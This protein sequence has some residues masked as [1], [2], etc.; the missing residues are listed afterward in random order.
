MR[1]AYSTPMA[2]TGLV[3]LGLAFFGRPDVY[4]R[5][6]RAQWEQFLDGTSPDRESASRNV[7]AT[8]TPN[9]V[10]AEISRLQEQVKHL[11]ADLQANQPKQDTSPARTVTPPPPAAVAVPDHHDVFIPPPVPSAAPPAPPPTVTIQTA[12]PRRAAPLP[13]ASSPIEN[14]DTL[15]SVMARLRQQPLDRPPPAIPQQPAAIPPLQPPQLPSRSHERLLQARA[16]LQAGH[17]QDAM[18][19]LQEAQVQLV[20]R[21]IAPDGTQADPEQSAADVA[22]A[23]EALGANDLARSHD[24]IDKALDSTSAGAARRPTAQ[25]YTP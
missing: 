2:A 15:R 18:R 8:D 25:A 5:Q 10:A 23:L 7:Q 4:L 24:Y 14:Q 17:I 19:L 9:G 13:P 12:K 22:H 20:F 16:A 21:P 1:L 6:I 11:E 3:L